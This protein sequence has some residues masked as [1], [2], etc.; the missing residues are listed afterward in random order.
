MNGRILKH[1][2]D[3]EEVDK[4]NIREFTKLIEQHEQVW[5]PA[6]E[7]LESINM[8]NEE[9]QRELRIGTLIT[10]KE[11]EDLIT[12]LR[13]SVDV[14]AWSYEDMPELDTDS[15]VHKVSLEEGCKPIKQKL[16]RTHPEVLI[17]VKAEIETT[18][19]WFF[20]SN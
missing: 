17:K 8:G 1:I 6:K 19:R 12:L 11:R 7:E 15:V 20:R 10:Q 5:K 2:I 9:S 16:R 18:E 4:H 13:D 3:V 14:F